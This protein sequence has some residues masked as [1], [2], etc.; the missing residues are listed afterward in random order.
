[1]DEA[2]SLI[3][4]RMPRTRQITPFGVRMTA[5]LTVVVVLIAGFAAF[6]IDQQHAADRRRATTLATQQV[7]RDAQAQAV[8]A[9]GLAVDDGTPTSS[10]QVAGLLNGQARDAA[11][12]ALSVAAEVAAGSSYDAA[13]PAALAANDQSLLYVDG[14]STAPSVVS[15]YNGAAGWAAAVHG[16]NATCFWVA[17]TP[18]GLTRYGSGSA[19]TGM[20]ALAADR[21]SW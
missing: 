18:D 9:Q 4:A 12:Q 14:P 16:A 1:M 10:G 17:V 19:C 8:A 13:R 3:A 20:A 21:P 6:V 2:F 7:E 15:V 5:M 11:G